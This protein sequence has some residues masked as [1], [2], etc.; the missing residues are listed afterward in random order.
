M[1]RMSRTQTSLP[2]AGGQTIAPKRFTNAVPNITSEMAGVNPFAGDLTNAFNNFFNK[3]NDALN[4]VQASNQAVK[5]VKLQREREVRDLEAQNAAADAVNNGQDLNSAISGLQTDSSTF[6][7]FITTFKEAFGANT[8]ARVWNDFALYMENQNPASFEALAEQWRMDNI[9]NGTG[10]EIVDTNMLA[11]WNQNYEAARVEAGRAAIQRTREDALYEQRRNVYNMMD[12]NEFGMLELN[13]LVASINSLYPTNSS[14]RNRSIAWGLARDNAVRLG[15]GATQRFLRLLRDP[16]SEDGQSLADR[17]P[18]QV[19]ELETETITRMNQMVTLDG[20]TA[21][22]AVSNQFTALT[23]NIE[24]PMRLQSELVRFMPRLIELENTPGVAFSQIQELRSQYSQKMAEIA[25]YGAGMQAFAQGARFNNWN[26]TLSVDEVADYQ[27]DFITREYDFIS[28]PSPREVRGPNGTSEVV[29]P[30]VAAA[31]SLQGSFFRYGDGAFSPELKG[32]FTNALRST[33]SGAVQRAVAALRGADPNGEI[34]AAMLSEDQTAYGIYQTIVSSNRAPGDVTNAVAS[35]EFQAAINEIG[36][37]GSVAEYRYPD[38]TKNEANA[39]LDE[40]LISSNLGE[41]IEERLGADGLLNASS[42]TLDARVR[43]AARDAYAFEIALAAADGVELTDDELDTRVADRMAS[44]VMIVDNIVRMREGVVGGSIIGNAVPN[45]VPGEVENTAKTLMDD[46]AVIQD[47][48]PTLQRT[49]N[50]PL[51]E[52]ANL[53]VRRVNNPDLASDPEFAGMLGVFYEGSA[54]QVVIPTGIP[55]TVD[56]QYDVE[57]DAQSDI[58]WLRDWW[59]DNGEMTLDG[60]DA[61][62]LKLRTVLPPSIRARRV[63]VGDTVQ[64]ELFVTPRFRNADGVLSPDEL[65][66]MAENPSG[67]NVYQVPQQQD[68]DYVMP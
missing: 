7:H 63:E 61:D 29:D 52:D 50:G 60:S 41:R 42:P 54:Q 18:V 67:V 30:T 27:Y 8:G 49:A 6:P 55:L 24:D 53:T 10:D 66:A 14:G 13:N 58:G 59:M 38:M 51:L 22:S 5:E 62:L 64:Y 11:S 16:E 32:Y 2:D 65:R 3:T 21:Y 35:P 36:A 44:S 34:A 40:R 4:T 31:E 15:V 19:Q 56:P 48:L 25:T 26:N 47:G 20:Q 43:S 39:A 1:A 33:D 46:I 37:A 9:G 57:G 12:S 28:D 68:L 23:Q 17:F 45:G